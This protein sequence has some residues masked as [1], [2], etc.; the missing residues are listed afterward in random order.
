LQEKKKRKKERTS[1]TKQKS[2]KFVTAF[3]ETDAKLLL[4]PRHQTTCRLPQCRAHEAPDKRGKQ[5]HEAQ[6]L[7]K[8][9]KKK[10]KNIPCSTLTKLANDKSKTSAR[11]VQ[12]EIAP[13]MIE[14][15][16]LESRN[17]KKKKKIQKDLTA[18][19]SP[20]HQ[21]EWHRDPIG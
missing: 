16:E 1:I 13:A 4:S 2:N 18:S 7:E 21:S 3:R 20:L 6:I 10:K 19:F 17:K 5:H 8:K 14:T 9:K 12:H 15:A 11:L